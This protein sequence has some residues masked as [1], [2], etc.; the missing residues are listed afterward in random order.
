MPNNTKEQVNKDEEVNKI[1]SDLNQIN[2][3]NK[4]VES[5]DILL[6]I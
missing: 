2:L 4:P 3:E 6:K 5:N 1:N